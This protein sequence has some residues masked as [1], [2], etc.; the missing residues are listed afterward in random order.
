MSV[1]GAMESPF[2]V[3]TDSWRALYVPVFFH[4]E[5]AIAEILPVW[6]TQYAPDL[7]I[8]M[9]KDTGPKAR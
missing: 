4:V 5:A 6:S 3:V 9:S 8:G 1:L 7:Y 2:P